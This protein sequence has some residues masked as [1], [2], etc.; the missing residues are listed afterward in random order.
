MSSNTRCMCSQ[1]LIYKGR[2][3]K[4]VS[5]LRASREE[6][7]SLAGLV[8]AGKSLA[9]VVSFD[10]D[11]YP[12]YSLYRMVTSRAQPLILAEVD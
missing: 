6:N 2:I 9:H 12:D 4:L 8:Q 5:A 7:K 3:E 1:A 11:D 10:V